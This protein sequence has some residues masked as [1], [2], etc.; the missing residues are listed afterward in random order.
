M[1]DTVSVVSQP[2]G[3]LLTET[4]RVNGLGHKRSAALGRWRTPTAVHDPAKIVL[5]T[6]PLMVRPSRRRVH[7]P[8]SRASRARSVRRLRDTCQPTTRQENTSTDHKGR[9][10]PSRRTSG[11]RWCRPHSWSDAVAV[12][13][14]WIRSGRLSAPR[15][16][17]PPDGLGRAPVASQE[18]VHHS[19]LA[20]FTGDGHG[21]IHGLEVAGLAVADG[22]WV[23]DK[24]EALGDVDVE[25]AQVRQVGDGFVAVQI[26]RITD[27][28]APQEPSSC[29][30]S[31]A[32]PVFH[33]S[34][35][36]PTTRPILKPWRSGGG[37][38]RGLQV[39]NVR[40]FSPRAQRES[41]AQPRRLRSP[42]L[43]RQ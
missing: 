1:K 12:N 3:V 19:S 18:T 33:R 24:S 36:A 28:L 21:A 4:A 39:R 9:R 31:E 27:E 32:G 38:G 25:V 37:V 14:H 43:R 10:R 2:G 13:D 35:L 34:S 11:S 20:D 6:N 42:R 23:T 26:L 8:I 17:G 7:N 22:V 15:C 30:R 29:R 16:S 40:C 5:W 41:R